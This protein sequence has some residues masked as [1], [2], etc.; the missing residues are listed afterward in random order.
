MHSPLSALATALVFLATVTASAQQL[1]PKDVDP[2]NCPLPGTAKS[3]P[4]KALNILKNRQVAPRA[5]QMDNAV[6]LE[7]MLAPGDDHGR[8]DE[9]T[10]ATIVGWVVNVQ[11][12]GHPETA[13]CGSMSLF[14]TDS[15]ITVGLSPNATE[16]E[17]LVVEVTPR[18][19]KDM[20]A[21][22][23]DW[24]TETLQQTLIGK[25]VKITGWLMFDLDHIGQSV[26]IAPNNPKDWRKT[27]WEIHPI[28]AMEVVQ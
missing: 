4:N 21:K 23:L 25:Q 12:G 6:T 13:N 15:H 22:G 8:F 28:T 10:G 18:W 14:Y 2:D 5:D 24:R 3:V 1:G 20:A 17:T 16:K 27:I 7:M 9:H 26:N 11:Q 19:R